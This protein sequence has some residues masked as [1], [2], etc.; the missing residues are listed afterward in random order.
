MA[1]PELPQELLDQIVDHAW[2]DRTSLCACNAAA[3]VLAPAARTHLFR[4]V[5]LDRSSALARFER[6]LAGALGPAQYVHTLRI[7]AHHFSS[8]RPG[9][10]RDIDSN[11][12]ARVPA[13]AGTLPALRALEL[14][15]LNWSALQLGPKS[16]SAFLD[17]IYRL[18]RLV[19]AN[20]HF[21][22]SSQVQDVLAVAANLT[23]FHCDRVY[24]S[25]WSPARTHSYAHPMGLR[26]EPD[27]PPLRRL[28]MRPGSPSRLFT[29]WLIYPGCEL[30]IQELDVHWRERELTSTLGE[31]LRA[32]GLHLECLF[33]DLSRSVGEVALSP[34]SG[35]DLSANPNLR[36]VRLEGIVLPDCSSWVSAL[37]AQLVSAKLELVEVVL[38]APC[39]QHLHAF[40]WPLLNRALAHSRFRGVQ[41]KF[42]VGLAVWQGNKRELVRDIIHDA[43]PDFHSRLLVK[44]Q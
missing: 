37:V 16:V 41:V 17:A 22:C 1:P 38:L 15:S 32:A 43:L 19:L 26:N 24:W 44:C 20:V 33:L 2:A 13:I 31:L 27:R 6:V 3:R 34:A 30:N 39:L 9:T 35:I 8:Y 28:I 23:E 21:G 42:D 25:Y 10:C 12:V 4:A 11:W 40:D 5:T 29:D 7:V 36:H 14:D 18:E